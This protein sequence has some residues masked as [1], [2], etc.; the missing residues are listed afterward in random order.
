MNEEIMM[1]DQEH[2]KT[3]LRERVI[4]VTFTKKDGSERQ[5]RC[6]TSDTYI[7]TEYA[8]KGTGRAMNDDV[9]PVF[10]VDA[11]QWRS[12]RYDSVLQYTDGENT[13]MTA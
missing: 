3:L 10:E 9:Q 5:I 2:L 7:P 11:N 4:D 1:I 8:P 13:W 12:F 6:T